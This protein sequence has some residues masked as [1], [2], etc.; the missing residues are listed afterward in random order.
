MLLEEDIK[1]LLSQKTETKNLDFKERFN[2]KNSSKDEKLDIIK[3]V[4]AMANTQDGGRI[5][6][7]VRDDNYEHVE[8]SDEDYQSFDQ[9]K[10]NDLLHNYTE[11]KHSCQVYKHK[12]DE[13]YIV[14][15]DTPEFEEV[16]IICKKDECSSDNPREQ[17]LKKGQIYIRTD[18]ATTQMVSSAEDMR[19]LLGRALVKKGDELLGMIERLIK[20]KPLKPSE[21]SKEKYAEEIKEAEAFLSENIGE[22]LKKYGHWAIYA[23]PTE[24]DSN[25]IDE[26]KIKELMQK[27]E[28]NLTTYWPF[29]HTHDRNSSNFPNGRQSYTTEGIDREGYRAFKSGLFVWKKAF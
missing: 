17:I 1:Q 24:Y 6:F 20:G 3:D 22:E 9:T 4:L 25:R 2:W 11:P 18:K 12:I 27:A 23:Y 16:P 5:V 29:P 21:E 28:A 10:V 8:M 15:I 14:V 13:K 26:K 19:E 7:G